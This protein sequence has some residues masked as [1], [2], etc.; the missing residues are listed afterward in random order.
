MVKMQR[1]HHGLAAGIGSDI[2]PVI[3][4]MR[5][6]FTKFEDVL[7]TRAL[8]NVVLAAV[9]VAAFGCSG[10]SAEPCDTT[11]D[12]FSGEVCEDQ[13]CIS[14]EEASNQQGDNQQANADAGGNGQDSG[15][16][17]SDGGENTNDG[18]ENGQDSGGEEQCSY[19][20]S[21]EHSCSSGHSDLESGSL[22]VLPDD[23]EDGGC[24]IHYDYDHDFRHFEPETWTVQACPNRD[25]RFRFPLWRCDT[26]TYAAY[27]RIEPVDPVCP[28]DEYATITL[29]EPF[30]SY[31]ESCPEAGRDYNCYFE[32]ELDDGGFEWVFK[33]PYPSTSSYSWTPAVDI[34]IATDAYFEYKVTSWIP[35]YGE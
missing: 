12:C 18:G 31:W 3:E 5:V 20:A 13:F 16:N 17:G 6:I 2:M 11:D 10:A 19:A 24:Q 8:M 28:L 9:L 27:L 22:A 33:P 25:H 14:E 34:E 35:P 21:G 23:M 30:A 4:Q 7:Q 26:V 15:G 1:R 29:E 32:E